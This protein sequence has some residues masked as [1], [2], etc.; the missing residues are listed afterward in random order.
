MAYKK[1][2]KSLDPSYTAKVKGGRKGVGEVVLTYRLGQNGQ[3]LGTR[4]FGRT[5]I[6]LAKDL[7]KVN[8][9]L[10]RQGMC[11]YVS[12]QQIT[13]PEAD[14]GNFTTGSL[15]VNTL[16][17][18][19]VIANSWVRAFAAWSQMRKQVLEDNPSIK[20]RWSDFKVFFNLDMWSHI[21]GGFAFP[22]PI[23][24]LFGA[25]N[26]FTADEWAYS[27]FTQPDHTT[28][29]T[30]NDYTGHMLGANHGSALPYT[31]QNMMSAGLVQ[32]YQDGRSL[33]QPKDMPANIGDG[34]YANLFDLGGQEED[35]IQDISEENDLPPYDQDNLQNINLTDPDGV[36]AAFMSIQSGIPVAQGGPMVVPLGLL[37][38]Q[39]AVS[40]DQEGDQ[41]GYMV[42]LTPGKYHGVHAESMGQ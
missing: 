20:A 3:F 12:S 42:T 26:E 7:S 27:Q 23:T 21:D 31:W 19:W 35:L 40:S 34:M 2:S 41:F 33:V 13:S 8:R 9:K 36:P 11:Y 6:D 16:P 18:T 38:L 17:N 14:P 24:N 28:G 22:S 4:N 32:A 5:Y 37:R 29:G 1:K 30:A 25:A 10:F 39:W 15:Q